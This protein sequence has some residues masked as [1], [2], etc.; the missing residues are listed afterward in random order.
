[1]SNV[2]ISTE[3]RL[4][5]SERAELRDR[6]SRDGEVKVCARIGIAR[7]TVGRLVAGLT[8]RA[9]TAVATRVYLAQAL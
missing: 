1:M 7:N 6:I 3:P 9:T 4:T 5:E 2:I 8:T